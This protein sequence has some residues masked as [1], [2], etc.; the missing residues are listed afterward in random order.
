MLSKY[1][2]SQSKKLSDKLKTYYEFSIKQFGSLDKIPKDKFNVI[3]SDRD[4][5]IVQRLID[6]KSFIMLPVSNSKGITHAYT[7][8]LWYYYGL[9][10]LVIQF[11]DEIEENSEFIQTIVSIIHDFLFDKFEKVIINEYPDNDD[12]I[13]I[14]H[15]FTKDINLDLKKFDINLNLTR[16][17]EKHYMNMKCNYAVWFD[18]FFSKTNE[19]INDDYPI[20]LVKFT[21][22][23]YNNF[24]MKILDSLNKYIDS[25]REEVINEKYIINKKKL[26][27]IDEIDSSID[28]SDYESDDNNVNVNQSKTNC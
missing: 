1:K 3:D 17:D 26:E 23:E 15:D 7:I 4:V 28:D 22:D 20:Y 25:I 2:I 6:L 11:E 12:D 8:G 16:I 14:R 18:T 9:P 5:E 13:I 27:S 24:C 10:D 19:A 21:K